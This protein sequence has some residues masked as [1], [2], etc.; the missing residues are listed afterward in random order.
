MANMRWKRALKH[1]A[2]VLLI[3]VFMNIPILVY[4]YGDMI[5]SDNPYRLWPAIGGPVGF[6]IFFVFWLWVNI[7]PYRDKNCPG[8]RLLIMRGGCTL[9]LYSLYGFLFELLLIVFTYPRFW[10]RPEVIPTAVL[11]G[12]GIYAA[13]VSFILL[14]NGILRMFLLSVRL[15]LGTRVLMILA[16]WVPLVN[17]MVLLYAVRVVMAEYD[18]TCFK[19]SVRQVRQESDMCKTRY[20]L[21]MVHGVGFRDLKYFNYWGRIPRELTRY[22]ATVYY[23]NQEAMGTIAYNAGDITRKVREVMAETGCEKVNIIAHSKGGLDSRYAV[24][25][26]GLGDCVASLTT[27]CTPHHGCRFVDYACRLPEGLYRFVAWCLDGSFRR[28][29]DQNPD[30]YTATHQF[31]TA[32]SRQFN[33]EVPDVAGVYYQSYASV[34]GNVLSD[35]LLWVPYCLIYPLEGPNDGLVSVESAKWGE[36]RSVF[37]SKKLRGISHGDMIDLKREDYKGFDVVE[38]F[39]QIVSELA[40]KGF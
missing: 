16:M 3:P 9:A 11:I 25:R 22:G 10:N 29:G 32:A 31:S 33:L 27:V 26:L 17:I 34:M 37:T 40:A 8:I 20:P 2:M 15:R 30:F 39:V 18:F 21:I 12:N 28:F 23:G 35:L 14:W 36:F 4:G 19:E 7:L 1:V 24:S 38:C 6:T 5:L 13:A